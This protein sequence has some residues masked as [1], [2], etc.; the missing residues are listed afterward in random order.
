SYGANGNRTIGRYS[1]LSRVEGGF[2]YINGAKIPVYTQGNAT[3]ANPDLKWETTIG[4][5]I[6]LDYSLFNARISGSI[7][8][9]NTNTEDLLYDVD[10]PGITRFESISDNL[11]RLHNKGLEVTT[12]TRN[13]STDK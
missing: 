12:S 11:G 5:N 3:L 8:Y 9:Y 6:G 4:I 1:T 7:D 10:I 13:I 2:N